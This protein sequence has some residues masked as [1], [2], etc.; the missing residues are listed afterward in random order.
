MGRVELAAADSVSQA[1][2]GAQKETEHSD[3]TLP[4]G[5]LVPASPEVLAMPKRP[6]SS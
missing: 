5:P 1:T 6:V 4:S 3:G 2:A